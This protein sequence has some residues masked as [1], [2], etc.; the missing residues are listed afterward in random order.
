MHFERKSISSSILLAVN[1]AYLDEEGQL[2]KSF[3]TL[4][5]SVCHN[6]YLGV[7]NCFL[8]I[9]FLIFATYFGND[10]SEIQ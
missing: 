5:N 3:A 1:G 9:R 6:L 4:T 7:S 10:Y 8:C 2:T